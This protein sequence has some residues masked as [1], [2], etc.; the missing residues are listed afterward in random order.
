MTTQ[1]RIVLRP[2]EVAELIGVGRSTLYRMEKRGDLPPRRKI[3][4]SVRG[5]TRAEIEE[6]AANRPI[7]DPELADGKEG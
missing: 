4:D 5:W 1:Q 6:W 2:G 3:T 7:A